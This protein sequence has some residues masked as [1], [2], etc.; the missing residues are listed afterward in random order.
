MG[1]IEK[2]E[3]FSKGFPPLIPTSTVPSRPK[4]GH[5]RESPPGGICTIERLAK[6]K[7]STFPLIVPGRGRR[8]FDR[9]K[10]GPLR[11]LGDELLEFRDRNRPASMDW[12]NG[13]D[14]Q[15]QPLNVI[16]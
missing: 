1:G 3:A 12:R 16:V 13:D 5:L 15:L 4:G 2:G 6:G 7:V 14:V 10:P 11:T 8:G 9:N